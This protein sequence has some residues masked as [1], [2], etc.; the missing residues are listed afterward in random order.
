MGSPWRT[1]ITKTERNKL[2]IR[3]YPIEGLL[4]SISFSEAIHLVLKGE[5]PDERTRTMLDALLV[6]FV[7]YG[8]VAPS[9]R[10]SRIA[11][12]AGAGI[13]QSAAAGLIAFSGL[14]HGGAIGPAAKMLSDGVLRSRREKVGLDEVSRE[15]VDER[16]SKGGRIPG[17]GHPLNKERDP[18]T[19][20]LFRLAGELSLAGEHVQL[21]KLI[22][23][24]LGREK[25]AV[26]TINPDSATAAILLDIGYDATL[27]P[28]LNAIG[29]VVGLLAHAHEEASRERP[30]RTVEQED[31][32][33]DGPSERSL[34]TAS[35]SKGN[36]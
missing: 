27:V 25:G 3:G 33:Y 21:C 12:S 9:V 30:F 7:D 10:V 29:R 19:D 35:S 4:G 11:S 15:I 36:P 6:A 24:A 22:R 34:P 13:V 1:A 18:R 23:D 31:I 17:F 2:L 20:K 5:L 26:L 16:L 32:V 28:A 14:S 8:I